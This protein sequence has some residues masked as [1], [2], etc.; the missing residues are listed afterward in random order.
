[1]PLHQICEVVIETIIV[2]SLETIYAVEQ[3][4]FNTIDKSLNLSMHSLL[5]FVVNCSSDTLALF[6]NLFGNL[7]G[8][9]SW[10]WSWS[11]RWRSRARIELRH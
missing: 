5:E 1:M 9:R 6:G 7:F 11:R 4:R 3:A 10:S 2:E 8:S